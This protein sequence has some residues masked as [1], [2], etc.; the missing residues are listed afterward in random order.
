MAYCPKIGKVQ[1]YL[2][3]YVYNF[4]STSRK[5]NDYSVFD[6][7]DT[8]EYLLE[9][10]ILRD[11]YEKYKLEFD[12]IFIGLYYVNTIITCWLQFDKPEFNYIKKV[13]DGINRKIPNYRSN[14]YVKQSQRYYRYIVKMN[15][16]E[17]KIVSLFIKF[18]INTIGKKKI[19]TAMKR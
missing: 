6:R 18:L 10:A 11:K 2:Y 15:I 12:S 7:L 19:V 14:P 8:A 1:E 5:K 16:W 9:Q 4:D 13:Y 17:L 3:H